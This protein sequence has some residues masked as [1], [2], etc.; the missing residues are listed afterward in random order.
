MQVKHKEFVF[1]S[2]IHKIENNI[3]QVIIKSVKRKVSYFWQE[4][5]RVQ[6]ENH[7]QQEKGQRGAQEMIVAPWRQV[8][9]QCC[10]SSCYNPVQMET[11]KVQ[12]Q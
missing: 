12:G 1:Y 4:P 5:G 10:Q 7:C 3:H 8:R 6:P 2:I 11:R 9:G